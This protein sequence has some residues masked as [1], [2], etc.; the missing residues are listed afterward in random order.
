MIS[1]V[2]HLNVFEQPEKN[3]FFNNLLESFANRE[4]VNGSWRVSIKGSSKNVIPAKAGIHNMLEFLDSRLRGSD[5]IWIIRG[6]LN[7]TLLRVLSK[8]TQY[9]E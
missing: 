8:F 7:L 2:L 3:H 4:M 9:Y 6:S 5:R 1:H